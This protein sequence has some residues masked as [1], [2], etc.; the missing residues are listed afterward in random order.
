LDFGPIYGSGP[1]SFHIPVF[2]SAS[3]PLSAQRG[4]LIGLVDGDDAYVLVAQ[5]LRQADV[6]RTVHAADAVHLEELMR[7]VYQILID[8][9]LRR[10]GGVPGKAAG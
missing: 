7:D 1:C 8:R 10:L 6:L 5:L 4:N 3:A 2:Y 9:R